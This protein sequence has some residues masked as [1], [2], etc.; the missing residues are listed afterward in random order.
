MDEEGKKKKGSSY[1]RRDKDYIHKLL[2]SEPAA[3]PKAEI[4]DVRAT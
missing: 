1:S 4:E 2:F 3:R